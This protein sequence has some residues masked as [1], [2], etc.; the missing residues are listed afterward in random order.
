MN[1]NRLNIRCGAR[2]RSRRPRRRRCASG[3]A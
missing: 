3:G 1:I 2:C